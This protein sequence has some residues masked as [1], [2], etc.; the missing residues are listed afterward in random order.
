MNR[1]MLIVG[2]CLLASL[3]A[4]PGTAA[5]KS[6]SSAVPPTIVGGQWTWGSGLDHS[7][8]VEPYGVYGMKGVAAPKNI[9][10]ARQSFVSWT[11]TS[12]SFWLFG[13][14]GHGA[15]LDGK[16]NDLW[17]WDGTNWT[18]MAGSN[19]PDG[20]GTYG[21]KGVAA[22]G[23]VPGARQGSASWTD[24]SGSLWLFGGIGFAANG[25]GGLNDLWKWDGTSW[26]W[27]SGSSGEGQAGVYGTKGLAAPGNVPGARRSSVSWSD[28]SGALWL[29]GGHAFL[30][31][32][33]EF[34][35]SDLWKWDGANW[36]W[37]S[38]SDGRDQPGTY[39]TKGVAAPGNAPGARQSAVS[40]V[41]AAGRFWLFGGYGYSASQAGFLND[42]W[43]WDGSSWTWVSGSDVPDQFGSYGTKG[44][45]APGNV[46][47]GRRSSIAW[48][49]P[50]GNLS[51]FG[52]AGFA[53]EYDGSL[54]DL[55]KWDG[56]NWTWVSGS[57]VPG[58]KGTYGTKGSPAP[59]NVPGGRSDSVS[60]RDSNGNVWLF[61]GVGIGAIEYGHLN[62]LWKWDGTSW[63]WV[64]GPSGESQVGLFGTKGVPSPSNIPR[65]RY[66]AASWTDSSGNLWLFGGS[67]FT[68]AG[69][70][71]GQLNDLWRWDG[72]NWTWMSGPD[73]PYG[74][75]V[76]G[77]KGV[78]ASGNMPG[79]RCCAV[80]W[81]D[82]SGNLWLFG[83][84]GAAAAGS[85][86]LN[87]LWKWDGTNWT[88]VSGSNAPNS[89]GAYG[90]K[91]VPAPGNVPW[92]RASSVS[93]TDAAGNFWLFGGNTPESAGG[94][95]Q[96]NDLW[97]WDGTN[98]T[99]MSGSNAAHEFG[100]YGTKGIAASGNVPGARSFSVSW[101]DAS[102]SL[103]LFGGY[104][105]AA[106]EWGYLNDLWK[107]NGTG[108]A[109]VSGSDL[110]NQ[111]G[112]YG[113]KGVA[114][115]GNGPGKQG[116]L[117]LLEG[118]EREVLA[119]R[120][121]F[122]RRVFWRIF[123][124]PLAL[125]WDELDL[126]QRID[127]AEPE[128]DVRDHER[129]GGRERPRGP[130]ARCLLGGRE[131]E[132][133]ALRR[134][135]IQRVGIGL[136]AGREAERPLGLRHNLRIRGAAGGRKRRSLRY[137]RDDPA[138]RLDGAGRDLPLDGPER[139]HV[140]GSRPHDPERDTGDG[141]YLQR[142]DDRRR[143]RRGAA[144]DD[145]GR[146][147]RTDAHRL[148]SGPGSGLVSSGP[149]GIDC[150]GVCANWFPTDLLV[151][152]TAVADAGSRFA[153]WAGA[154]CAGP[155]PCGVT[156]NGS[157]SVSATL[158]PA[159][160]VG[161]H[162]LTP[163]ASWRR[164]TLWGRTAVRRSRPEGRAPSPSADSAAFRPTRRRWPSTSPSRTRRRSAA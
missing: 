148:K 143:L 83:G 104:G 7:P 156:M 142:R 68:S 105:G 19:E 67:G 130:E 9:P 116:V 76:Y 117:P 44:T 150:G 66:S 118:R 112:V 43:K 115:P 162:T 127:H 58:Q 101:T 157:T 16:L 5:G 17:K 131:W 135:G 152:L 10:G 153:G 55:W 147:A 38:G 158:L 123:Q 39:G 146:S 56:T 59:A 136:E 25:F 161:F 74:Y 3:T 29:F 26:T 78:A 6:A 155:D 31:P 160:G 132:P 111:D 36:T 138:H 27:V 85:G 23:N 109:W 128:G 35:H 49:D 47:G 133:V 40:W 141:R 61:G 120:R 45:G 84:Y 154:G 80:S 73:Q 94:E 57:D 64:S 145:R 33:F 144:R 164:G 99:W 77:T 86:Y 98:W 163:V 134:A 88:W 82:P 34:D 149:A 28:A 100:T 53:A 113:T 93:W 20:F 89:A 65:P 4:A 139:L 60:W 110:S 18:W 96:R 41:D 37:V 92:A 14:E 52:G 72:T 2:S 22:P 32:G 102:G 63:T 1:K 151:T 71:D 114:A 95:D 137:G 13:G 81:T 87:D 126:G 106:A 140:R 69:Y 62:D 11:D 122:Q 90:S 54:N 12:G 8:E 108:W 30:P 42:L 15:T 50:S 125:G 21:T 51:L 70:S 121:R 91:G 79:A 46:P 97:R 159:G 103:W 107:W 129:P 124:R 75:G 48:S 24:G 119:F